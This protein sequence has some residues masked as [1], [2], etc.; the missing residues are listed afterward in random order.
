VGTFV[1]EDV[2]KVIEPRLLLKPAPDHVVPIRVLLQY[3]LDTS[4]N[5]QVRREQ[6]RRTVSISKLALYSASGGDQPGVLLASDSDL[7]LLRNGLHHI[8]LHGEYVAQLTIIGLR[9]KLAL[10]PRHR[11]PKVLQLWTE[12]DQWTLPHSVCC[13]PLVHYCALRRL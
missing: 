10:S 9:P 12:I 6:Q 13:A 3:G 8:A 1:V 11:V 2:N 7:N 5:S 4:A